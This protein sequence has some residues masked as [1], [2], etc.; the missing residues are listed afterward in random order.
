LYLPSSV[1]TVTA[2][3][4][5]LVEEVELPPR[6]LCVEELRRAALAIRLTTGARLEDSVIRAR[7]AAWKALAAA[8]I[9]AGL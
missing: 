3:R 2:F 9:G 8:A 1:V 6:L 4:G 7:Q 5:A